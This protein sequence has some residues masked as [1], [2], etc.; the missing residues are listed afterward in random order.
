MLRDAGI[1]QWPDVADFGKQNDRQFHFILNML[2]PANYSEFQRLIA[3]DGMVIKVI[4]ERDYLIELR[5]IFYEGSQ[6]QVYSNEHTQEQFY[7]HFEIADVTNVRYQV[8][9][10]D[11]LIEPLLRMTPRK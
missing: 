5:N 10:D 2:S 6:K 7:N 1:N 3:D 8:V 11:T 4:P 9:L